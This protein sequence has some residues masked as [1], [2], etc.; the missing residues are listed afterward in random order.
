MHI[1]CCAHWEGSKAAS[2]S[3]TCLASCNCSELF[4]SLSEGIGLSTVL[5]FAS[6]PGGS[7]Q[8]LLLNPDAAVSAV[9]KT[10]ESWRGQKAASSFPPTVA[11]KNALQAQ[12]K[13]SFTVLKTNVCIQNCS[14]VCFEKRIYEIMNFFFHHTDWQDL[15]KLKATCRLWKWEDPYFD[16]EKN[17]F[18]F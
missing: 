14:F 7:F 9:N 6:H 16:N 2:S 4:Q 3:A 12:M 18:V 8:H 1:S 11:D 5:D 13:V 10:L 17:V 15:I